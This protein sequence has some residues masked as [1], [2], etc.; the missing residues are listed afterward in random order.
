ME[1]RFGFL[2]TC[3]IQ[4]YCVRRP[5]QP[6]Q[7][8][9]QRVAVSPCWQR[10]EP[11]LREQEA[12][13]SNPLAPTSTQGTRP[14]GVPAE[15]RISNSHPLR[16]TGFSG[17]LFYFSEESRRQDLAGF[18]GTTTDE[19]PLGVVAPIPTHAEPRA[20]DPW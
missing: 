1:G 7:L 6:L 20:G 2:R 15:S 11:Q 17:L 12:G 16:L 5:V 9:Q 19:R 10:T 13:G 8:L 3:C 14:Q 4:L 18:S